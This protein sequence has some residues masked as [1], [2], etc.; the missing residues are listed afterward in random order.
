MSNR[1]ESLEAFLEAGNKK[2]R[3]HY[4]RTLREADKLGIRISQ[5]EHVTDLDRVL[6]LI[7]NVDRHHHNAPNP[8]MRNL[9]TNFGQTQGTW[10]EAHIGD[11]LVGGGLLLEDNEAQMT[12][13]LALEDNL[14]YLYFMLIYAC[15][16]VA[17]EKRVRL[18]RWGSGAYEVKKQLGF[19]LECNNNAIFCSSQMLVSRIVKLLIP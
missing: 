13:A 10:I 3:Q 19:E 12:T 4:K 8:W 14:P 11:R 5:P 6:S 18:L 15:L 17:F 9:L 16:E 1:W 2:D 7:G